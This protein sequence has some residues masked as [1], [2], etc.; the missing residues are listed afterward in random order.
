VLGASVGSLAKLLSL[1]F[2]KLVC[3]SCTIAFPVAWWA[4]HAWLQN[5]QYRT[6]IHWWVFVVGG[7]MALFIAILTVSYQAVRVAIINPDLYPV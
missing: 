7:L 1:E 5:Y 6:T 4:L 3:L 2:L